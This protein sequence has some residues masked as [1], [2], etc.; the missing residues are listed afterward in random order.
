[1]FITPLL[2]FGSALLSAVAA[3]GP[4]EAPRAEQTQAQQTQ[5]EQTPAEQTQEPPAPPAQSR[6][7]TRLPSTAITITV[8][9]GELLQFPD[10]ASRVSVSDPA[11]AD[12]VV[13]SPHDVVLNGKAPGNTTIM[14][15]HGENISPYEVAVEPDLSEIQKQLR[16]SFPAEQI[17]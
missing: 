7:A 15:W 12:A 17:D 10:E 11:I 16:T 8:G 14:I 9:K 2:L 5:P 1:I 13:I 4:T 3:Q 6:P